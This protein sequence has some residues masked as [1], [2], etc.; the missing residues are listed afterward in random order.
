M[1][2]LREKVYILARSVGG[3]A[4]GTVNLKLT[5]NYRIKPVKKASSTENYN[6]RNRK[7]FESY[8]PPSVRSYQADALII[9]KKPFRCK[10]TFNC[11]ILLQM[12]TCE[13]ED[14]LIIRKMSNLQKMN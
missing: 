7:D 13:V 9:S 8:A 14:S 2:W 12:K 11:D 3:C 5:R 4:G 6:P 10:E 1:S